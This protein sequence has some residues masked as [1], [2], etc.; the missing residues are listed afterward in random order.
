M[1]EIPSLDIAIRPPTQMPPYLI[2]NRSTAFRAT[3]GT[4]VAGMASGISALAILQMLVV[5]INIF[6]DQGVLYLHRNQCQ[7]PASRKSNP[8]SVRVYV[9][10]AAYTSFN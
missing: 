2:R 5:A 3:L 9:A 4:K 8:A 6:N 1:N 7:G 10:I